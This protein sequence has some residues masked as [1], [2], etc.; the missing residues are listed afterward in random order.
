MGYDAALPFRRDST[1]GFATTGTAAEQTRQ[2]LKILLLTNPGER[3]MDPSFGVGLQTFLFQD[4]TQTTLGSI[5]VRVRQQ[6]LKYLP[7]VKIQS[8]VFE[9]VLDSGPSPL[10]TDLDPNTVGIKINYSY[11]GGAM[12]Y[13][14]VGP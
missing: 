14:V 5:E 3:V 12:D 13:I 7:Y 2:N 1:S 9:S 4:L 10:I 6:V 8:I 11:N